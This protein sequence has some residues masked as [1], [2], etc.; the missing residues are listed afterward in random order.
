VKTSRRLAGWTYWLERWGESLAIFWSSYWLLIIGAFLLIGSVV[1]KWVEF[2]FS[3]NLNGFQLS[4]LHGTGV[5]PHASALSFGALGVIVLLI[6]LVW[7][8]WSASAPA[9]IGAILLMLCVLVPAHIAFRQPL[10]LRRLSNEL[11]TV[12][13]AKVFTKEYL[14]EN[15]GPGE[16]LPQRLVLDTAWGRFV[17]AWSFLRL[18]W[19][20]FGFGSLLI[21]TYGVDRQRGSALIAVPLLCLPLAALII[22]VTPAAIGQHYFNSGSNAKARG[23]N[24]EAIADYQRAMRWDGWH[25]QDVE[26]YAAIGQLQKQ[27]GIAAGSPE[28]HITRA[29]ELRDDSQF[30]AALF[31]FRQVAATGGALGATANR[32]AALTQIALGL[33]LYKNGAIGSAVTSWQQALA[34]DP[35]QLQALLYLARGYYDLGRYQAGVET[36]NRLV[37]AISDHNSMLGDTYSMAGDCYA[38]LGRDADARHYY[39]LSLSAD[40]IENYWA[41][42]GLIGQ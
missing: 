12:T 5:I 4:V 40:S 21:F 38:K 22:V 19:Y 33:G 25:A 2:P 41:L 17:A 34:L 26:L 42:T 23:R 28:R 10:M 32:E 35:T 20:C 9:L 13:T 6:G 27:A 31:E 11:E 36:V 29:V 39:N 16:Y 1:L 24:Q 3:N 7:S 18:G 30:E 37:K 15:Y 14:S 8:R